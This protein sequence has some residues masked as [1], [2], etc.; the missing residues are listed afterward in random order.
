MKE[1][2]LATTAALLLALLGTGC[3]GGGKTAQRPDG[4]DSRSETA[5]DG[6]RRSDAEYQALT[7]EA[8]MRRDLDA[9]RSHE[10]R[11]AKLLADMR[12]E[13]SENESQLAR[14]EKRL[15]DIRT[16][17]SRFEEALGG[18][19]RPDAARDGFARQADLANA[20]ERRSA[21]DYEYARRQPTANLARDAA[22]EQG[23]REYLIRTNIPY[24]DYQAAAGTNQTQ[25]QPQPAL[26]EPSHFAGAP[27]GIPRQDFSPKPQPEP[28][29]Q[30]EGEVMVWNP[31]DPSQQLPDEWTF[32]AAPQRANGSA[33]M[34]ATQPYNAPPSSQD[35]PYGSYTAEAFSPDL[36]L[37]K[38][39]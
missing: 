20:P 25:P 11:Q 16:Q 28:Q 26:R 33:A 7:P 17:I 15:A 24:D 39:G 37:G 13:L 32:A 1:K 30:S 18:A 22:P 19:R 5:A 12:G 8:S 23:N 2:V 4:D 14:E 35:A 9:L 38:G 6:A 31:G 3:F 36:Y 29:S 10:S 34:A 27:R 21:A